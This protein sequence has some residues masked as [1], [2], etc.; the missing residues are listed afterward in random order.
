MVNVHLRAADALFGLTIT[1][2]MLSS[3]GDLAPQGTR[4][5]RH[6][7]LVFSQQWLSAPQAEQGIGARSAQRGAAIFTA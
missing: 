5:M 6:A 7:R 4:N 3:N 1:A 2:A